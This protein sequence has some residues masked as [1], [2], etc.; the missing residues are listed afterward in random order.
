MA[1]TFINY[2]SNLKSWVPKLSVELAKV[3]VNRARR[4]IYSSRLWSFLIV[5]SQLTTPPLITAGAATFTQYSTSVVGDA[6]ASAAWTGLANPLITMRQIRQSGGPIY[7][8]T[9]ANFAIPNAVVLT[10]DRPY[11]EPTVV[12]S[13]YNMYQCYYPPTDPLTNAPTA[14][15]EKWLSVYDPINGYALWLNGTQQ[16]LNSADPQRSNM[17][18]PYVVCTY[19]DFP[20]AGSNDPAPYFELW[21]HPTDGISRKCFYKSG[22]RDWT[23]AGEALPSELPVELLETRARYRAYEWAEANK[24]VHPELQKTNWMAMRQELMN[25]LDRS[26]YPYLLA[27]AKAEDE[28]RMP[29][30]FVK[31]SNRAFAYPIDSNFLQA[32]AFSWEF[33]DEISPY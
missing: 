13:G 4:D 33:P 32:H 11:Q 7:N 27:K 5:E 18:Q 17:G 26:S 2:Y 8:I 16:W 10:F 31:S 21:P 29:I 22:K 20:I 6:I 15:F 1:E 14:D 25:P 12:A 9:A 30:N 3:L 23:A 28:N 24:G 19:K